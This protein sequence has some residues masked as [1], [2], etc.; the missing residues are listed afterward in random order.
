VPVDV[1]KMS[2]HGSSD[3]LAELYERTG[4]RLALISVGADNGYGHPTDAAL[5]LLRAAG[6]PWLRTDES[7]SIAV[8]EVDGAVSAWT[9]RRATPRYPRC[10]GPC[11]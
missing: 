7:G 5:S 8:F 10:R 6:I 11:G 9:A 3:Q 1:V 4:A 2:H